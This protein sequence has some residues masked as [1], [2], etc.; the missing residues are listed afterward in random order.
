MLAALLTSL[1]KQADSKFIALG[2]RPASKDHWFSRQLDGGADY[3]QTHAARP[4]DKPFN[5]STWFRANPSLKHFPDLLATIKREAA[6][7]KLEPSLASMF[8]ALRLNLG[9]PETLQ[10]PLLDAGVWEASEGDVA[11]LGQPT[12]GI[13]LGATAAMSAIS[14][15]WPESGRLESMA[16]FPALPRLE[17]REKQDQCPGAYV[18]MRERG[19]LRRLGD[20]FTVPIEELLDIAVRRWGTPTSIGADRFRQDLLESALQSLG[21]LHLISWRG[22]GWRDG[23]NDVRRFR[24]AMV[25]GKVRPVESLLMRA[26]MA[27][28]VC[29]RNDAGDDK[30]AKTRERQTRGKDDAAAAAILAVAE[31]QREAERPAS[32]FS[33]AT[34][35][36]V[37]FDGRMHSPEEMANA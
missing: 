25:D 3:C 32:T 34:A 20:S 21:L 17:E 18:R 35:E 26:A 11:P 19:E 16:V 13:D 36:G 30:L 10:T 5:R 12:F 1:G 6:K 24:S 15:Y 33:F 37:Y 22:Q 7:A 8:S 27:N 4:A 14:C 31:G 29:L 23:A 2:T 28:A 9:T